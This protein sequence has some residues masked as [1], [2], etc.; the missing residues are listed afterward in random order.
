M[1][2]PPGTG[3]AP[4]RW[5]PCALPAQEHPDIARHPIGIVQNLGAELVA[6]RPEMLFPSLVRFLGIP[7]QA[8]LPIRFEIIDGP[9]AISAQVAGKTHDLNFVLATFRG[10]AYGGRQSL[11][12]IRPDMLVQ[13]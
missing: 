2:P 10:L 5:P 4:D 12:G 9:P 1:T 6:E 8:V 7:G 11:L 13:E 3:R